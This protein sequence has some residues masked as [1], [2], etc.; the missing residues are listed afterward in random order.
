MGWHVS[1]TYPLNI[2]LIS[3]CRKTL[4]ILDKPGRIIAVL[5]GRPNGADWIYVVDDAAMVL[6][7]VLW[8][9]GEEM[10]L[11]SKQSLYHRWGEFLAVPVGVSFGGS[12]VVRTSI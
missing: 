11:F 9:G 6:K 5:V 3:G 2:F 12:Q 1:K 7:E 10:G 8:L 4:L